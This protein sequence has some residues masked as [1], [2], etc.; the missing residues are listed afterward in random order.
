LGIPCERFGQPPVEA[1]AAV[2]V[3]KE[4]CAA[5]HGRGRFDELYLCRAR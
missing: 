1:V 2:G 5:Y 3:S 4:A